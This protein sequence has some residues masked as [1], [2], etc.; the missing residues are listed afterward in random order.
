M[1]W[2]WLIIPLLLVV[3]LFLI[4]YT[5]STQIRQSFIR[6]YPPSYSIL[7]PRTVREVVDLV[8]RYSHISIRGAGYSSGG[9]TSASESIALD[10]S[11]L[12]EISVLSRGR[13]RV[14]A[15]CTWRQ[16]LEKLSPLGLSVRSMQSY[17]NFSVGGSISVNA[18]GQD[19]FN[20]PFL[21]SIE[22]I[23]LITPNG[24]V[25]TITPSSDLFRYVV[26]GYGLFGVITEVILK[27]TTNISLEKKV[28]V[29]ATKEY[30]R[31]LRELIDNKDCV[32]ASARLDVSPPTMFDQCIS[33]AYYKVGNDVVK[34]PLPSSGEDSTGH[35][36][37]LMSNYEILKQ[38]RLDTEVAME[39]RSRFTTRNTHLSLSVDS[40]KSPLYVNDNYILQEYFLP[41]EKLNPFLQ[42]LKSII[43]SYDINLIN[44]TLRYV[45][46]PRGNRVPTRTLLPLAGHDT[47]LSYAPDE[48]IAIV[49][50]IDL[51]KTSGV[52]TFTEW[53]RR[54]I[55]EA[56]GCRGSYYLPYH[57]FA[58][59]EQFRLAYPNWNTFIAKKCEIDPTKKF[60]STFWKF[61]SQ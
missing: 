56:L 11:R 50:Y 16:I 36:F 8:K 35:L 28:N 57:L 19:L 53:T 9:H 33:L 45:R 24:N 2:K 38:F 4:R 18:H 20:N 41:F 10:L 58:S 44:A 49:L 1:R 55:M 12:N 3:I 27:T 42:R 5:M 13:I 52:A 21:T 29:I 34:E 46:G 7:T 39:S 43:V 54:I 51:N 31:I 32:F 25:L 15:G 22:S 30:P 26:G 47:I 61:I 48:R 6:L 17:N 59:K 40:L 14:G 60:T 37:G 23:T